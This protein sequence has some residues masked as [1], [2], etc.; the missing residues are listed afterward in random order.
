MKFILLIFITTS[1]FAAETIPFVVRTKTFQ[2]IPATVGM[3]NAVGDPAVNVITQVKE[4]ESVVQVATDKITKAIKEV[5]SGVC[6]TIRDGHVKMWF[7]ATA[8]GGFI[9]SE[10]SGEGGLEIQFDCKDG[11]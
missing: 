11:K 2:Q 4:E 9:V 1:S 5:R 7:K 8:K 10:T 6:D 3:K